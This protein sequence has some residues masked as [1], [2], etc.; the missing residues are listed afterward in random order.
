MSEAY[1]LDDKGVVTLTTTRRFGNFDSS[2]LT[3]P[4]RPFVQERRNLAVASGVN[5]E[6]SQYRIFYSDGY[7]L[8]L[9]VANERL[10]GSMPVFFANP[11]TCWCEGETPDGSETSFFG[12][13]NGF[14]YKMDIGPDF[15]GA[16]IPAA[17]TLNF[18]AEGASRLLK[19]YR[20]ASLEVSGTG[21]ATFDFGYS[22]GYDTTDI[23]QA[24]TT[25][26]AVPFVNN[27][28]DNFVWDTFYWDG[29]GL[30]PVEVQCDGTA[31]NIALA[32]A[33]NTRL[34][35]PFTINS[36]TLHYSVRRGIR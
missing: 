19:R 21:Y 34:A 8:Y 20:R 2:T 1:S 33:S 11:V 36:A 25:T 29:R 32:V 14:V 27:R 18:N 13:T 28:W 4:I 12:S 23:D 15:D 10:L 9:T 35:Q 24:G 3:Y 22:L 17:I 16:P 31:E 7:G 30:A 5:R 26:Y 6:K